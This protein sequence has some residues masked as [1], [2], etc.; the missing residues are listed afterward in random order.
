[1]GKLLNWTLIAGVTLNTAVFSRAAELTAWQ[2]LGREVFQELI[3]TD[4]TYTKGDTTPAA[5]VLAR[6]FLAAGFPAPDV[7]VLGPEARNRNLVVRYRRGT[8]GTENRAPVLLLAH[9]DVVEAKR[10]DWSLEPFKLTEQDG[11]FYGRGTSDNKDGAAQLSTA[12][13]RLRSEKFMPNRDLI[14]AL[15]AGEESSE[16]Y[17]GVEWLLQN[18]RDLV[19]AAFCLN[20]DAGG[21]EQR[22]GK[23]ML[24]AVQAAEKVYLSFRLEAKAPGGHSSLPTADNPIYRLSAALVELSRFRFEPRLNEISRSYFAKMSQIETGQIA[25]DMTAVLG[26]KPDAA[27]LERLSANPYFNALL[28]TTAVATLIEGGH[29]ENALPQTARATV[30]CR[31]LPGESPSEV[32]AV[33]RRIGAGHQITLAPL[34]PSR[35]SPASPLTPEVLQAV[36]RAVT[37][38]WPGLPV[39][40]EMETGATDA[41]FLRR[42]GIPTYGI[43]GT[44]GDVDDIRAHGKDERVATGN[45]YDGLGFEYRLIRA[46]SEER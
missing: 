5:E 37:M 35:P 31:L 30:N 26:A 29:A 18:H 36:E 21:V 9:L 14:L 15:T 2:R 11:Y 19:S 24:Y 13:L 27:A 34:R 12:F 41:V 28:R 10:E 17:N 3:E 43:A 44:G 46:V 33:L 32:E 7:Q 39:V 4:T 42:V 22:Q 40:P 8:T 23:R 38:V 16:S 6:R 25:M 1:M 45:F 20:T